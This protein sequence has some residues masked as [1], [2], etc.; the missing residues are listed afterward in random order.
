MI[1]DEEIE[2]GKI[3][4]RKMKVGYRRNYGKK[5]I[6]HEHPDCIRIAY[7]WLDAQDKTKNIRKISR[8]LKGLI[9]RWAGRY[10]SESDVEVAATLHPDIQGEYPNYNI[11]TY[12]TEPKRSRLDDI[13]EA[14]TQDYNERHDPS[15]Y[16]KSEN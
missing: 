11:S 13:G 12:F 10:V 4:T 15:L 1:T 14:L 7:E 5:E 9:E 2:M 16:K 3:E 8:P 6:L